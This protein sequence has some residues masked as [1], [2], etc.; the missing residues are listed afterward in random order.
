M[1]TRTV[2]KFFLVTALSLLICTGLS[3]GSTSFNKVTTL[4][5]HEHLVLAIENK[6]TTA[7][8]NLR[9]GPGTGYPI[10]L[11]I[12]KGATVSVIGYSG[13]WS[14]LTY[15]GKTGYSSSSYLTNAAPPPVN[16]AGTTYVTTANLNLRTG[17]GAQ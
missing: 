15:N 1:N 16:T 9:T 2:F 17:P 6:I 13:S 12:P 7:N 3:L 11:T 14:K 5:F 10:I 4:G 8:L